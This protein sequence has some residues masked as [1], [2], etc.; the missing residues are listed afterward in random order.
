[1]CISIICFFFFT[2]SISIIVIVKLSSYFKASIYM[3]CKR[4]SAS[5]T[6]GL[7]TR[8]PIENQLKNKHYHPI[9]MMAETFTAPDKKSLNCGDGR[10]LVS[11][12]T[13]LSVSPHFLHKTRWTRNT[14]IFFLF[15]N[16]IFEFLLK[17]I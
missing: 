9:C 7:T 16:T 5:G 2:K 12:L 3:R 14:P 1:M 8:Q 6:P 15:K 17:K 4:I 13:I 11:M 10:T